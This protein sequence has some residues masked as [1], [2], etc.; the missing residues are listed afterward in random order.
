MNHSFGDTFPPEYVYVIPKIHF[1]K[2]KGY[3]SLRKKDTMDN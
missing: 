3:T 2:A 1:W